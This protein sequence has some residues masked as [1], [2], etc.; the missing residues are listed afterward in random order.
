MTMGSSRKLKC[1]K[2]FILHVCVF[3]VFSVFVNTVD[4]EHK[5]ISSVIAI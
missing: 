4:F 5:T 2:T 3:C 1:Y